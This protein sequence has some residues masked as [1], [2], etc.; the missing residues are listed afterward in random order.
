ML[1]LGRYSEAISRMIHALLLHDHSVFFSGYNP[2]QQPPST[3]KCA[4]FSNSSHRSSLHNMTSSHSLFS[5]VQCPQNEAIVTGLSNLL[6]PRPLTRS[7]SWPPHAWPV[8]QGSLRAWASGPA[9][10]GCV[11][12]VSNGLRCQDTALK[13]A[14]YCLSGCS[15]CPFCC[16]LFTPSNPKC[17][18]SQEFSSSISP[19]FTL[20][21]HDVRRP[22]KAA[23]G[24][25][26]WALDESA[27]LFLGIPTMLCNSISN[28]TNLMLPFIP[29]QTRLVSLS[30]P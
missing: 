28:F 16:F 15:F 10:L 1:T 24:P 13:P 30:Q 9:A 22:L 20:Q 5:R 26:L 4:V 25:P 2:S 18:N 8:A 17:L 19:L 23:N 14:F 27:G 11:D 7:H 6:S 3:P 21:H 12:L 29:F